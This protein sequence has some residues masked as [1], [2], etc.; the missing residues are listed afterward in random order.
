MIA[1][2]ELARDSDAN[3]VG[4]VSGRNVND[5]HKRRAAGS[6]VQFGAVDAETGR[7]AVMTEPPLCRAGRCEVPS[8]AHLVLSLALVFF[9]VAVSML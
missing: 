3:G 8:V 9:A 5:A 6:S 2:N 4:N 7:R 1:S